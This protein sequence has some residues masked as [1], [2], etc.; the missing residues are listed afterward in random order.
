MDK[1]S[2]RRFLRTSLSIG[3]GAASASSRGLALSQSGDGRTFHLAPDGDDANPGTKDRPFRTLKPLATSHGGEVRDGDTV[4]LHDGTYRWSD[5]TNFDDVRELTIG[6]PQG[7]TPVIDA[8]QMEGEANS[9]G[10]IQFFNGRDCRV[11]GLNF[12]Q[13]PGPAVD[14]VGSMNPTV[15]GCRVRRAGGPGIQLNKTTGGAVRDCEVLGGFGPRSDE[16]GSVVGGDADGIA[17]SGTTDTPS[18]DTVV[19]YNLVHHNSDD[20]LDFYKSRDLIVRHNV[21]YANGFGLDGK[22]AGKAP[23]KGIK[24]GASDSSGDGGHRVYNNAAWSNGHAG[25]GWNGADLPVVCYNNT[26]IGNGRK[27]H[28]R[29]DLR[30]NDFAFYGADESCEVYNNVGGRVGERSNIDS[31]APENVAGN[32]WQLDLPPAE[33]LF[34]SAE[35]NETAAPVTPKQYLGVASESPAVDAG[36]RLDPD[37]YPGSRRTI[38]AATEELPYLGSRSRRE[39]LPSSTGSSSSSSVIS[40]ASGDDSPLGDSD[41]PSAAP[42]QLAGA[43]GIALTLIGVPLIVFRAF[44]Q[45]SDDGSASETVRSTDNDDEL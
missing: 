40:T 16:N 14:F 19:E 24:L 21:A 1:P 44:R 25:I 36:V 11:V 12:S 31:I 22:P 43:V 9:H 13:S 18:T 32:S 35:R 17:V 23:G 3:L 26:C 7:A 2:R 41:D 42:G 27:A 28:L 34:R 6:A 37:K 39:T 15:E 45:W 10:V 5:Q 20:G 33:D 38:G 30:E 8:Q 29:E 4:Y